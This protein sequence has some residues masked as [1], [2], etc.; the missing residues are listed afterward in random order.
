MKACVSALSVSLALVVTT[1]TAT[2]DVVLNP[3]MVAPPVAVAPQVA[4]TTAYSL[5][6]AEGG[7][8]C[9]NG[10]LAF[11]AGLNFPAG[12][13]RVFKT[14]D[15]KDNMGT[16]PQTYSL[17]FDILPNG[18][19]TNIRPDAAPYGLFSNEFL[20]A[21]AAGWSL[22]AQPE[23]LKGCKMAWT[24]VTDHAPG[25][26]M[27]LTYEAL[28][29]RNY[30]AGISQ[31]DLRSEAC[32]TAQRRIRTRA[33]PDARRL[34]RK[35][36]QTQWV[37]ENYDVLANGKTRPKGIL[38]SD[39]S[40]EN[41]VAV[42]RALSEAVYFEG[43]AAS[44]CPSSY[45]IPAD[46]LPADDRALWPVL[47]ALNADA[48]DDESDSKTCPEETRKAM[49]QFN[50]RPELYPTVANRLNIEGV[51]VLTYDVAPWGQVRVKSSWAHPLPQFAS[52]AQRMLM[53][54]TLKPGPGLS[55]CRVKVRFVVEK[56][57]PEETAE[58]E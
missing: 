14:P 49:V 46:D 31:S 16:R 38:R 26:L 2:A 34:T 20:P 5:T 12:L 41:T 4:V 17:R 45:V 48:I 47:K 9:D 29:M 19:M 7:I 43:E 23:T 51:A 52:A 6:P 10:T 28:L 56:D 18:R 36:G 35:P 32:K 37:I 3:D 22:G 33:Y 50:Y 11:P 53:Q 57:K 25:T 44:N 21:W 24:I 40:P 55:G 58:A 1:T 8:R 27:P 30:A 54:S 13:I 42:T 15:G 39:M